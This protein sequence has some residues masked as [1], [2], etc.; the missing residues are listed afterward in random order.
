MLNIKK[1]FQK[2]KKK[3]KNKD[4]TKGNKTTYNLENRLLVKSCIEELNQDDYDKLSRL[5]YRELFYLDIKLKSVFPGSITILNRKFASTLGTFR[6]VKYLEKIALTIEH[7]GERHILIHGAQI[8]HFDTAKQ[9][10]LYAFSE[11]M[12][13]RFTPELNNAWNHVF[14]EVFTIMKQAMSKV[15]RRKIS[16]KLNSDEDNDLNLLNDIGGEEVILRVHKRFY[17]EL[18]DHPWLGAF[19]YGKSKETL[20]KK[21]SQFM[22]A[23]FNGPNNYRGDTPAFIHMHMF[24]TDKMSD[25]RSELLKSTIMNEGLSE[26]I[27]DR[28]LKVDNAF[29]PG[30]VKKSI[31]ECV[32]KCKGQLPV[33][34]EKP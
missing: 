10:L 32:M 12:K 29:R 15:N 16:R 7:L 6:D 13:E 17:D 25:V 21:Q 9:A 28:W 4:Q 5:F 34:A 14:D 18:F 24:I 27:A 20:I 8:E 31:D 19:F 22:I 30:I 11:H 3:N 23:A 2:N 1:F 26:S 33:T